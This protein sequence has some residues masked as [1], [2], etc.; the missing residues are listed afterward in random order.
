MRE[1]TGAK[2][3][4]DSN[5]SFNKTSQDVSIKVKGGQFGIT[6][7]DNAYSLGGPWIYNN[8]EV[9]FTTNLKNTG[10]W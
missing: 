2:N 3:S 10:N 4:F 6:I 8:E 1:F 5:I 7:T 9:T